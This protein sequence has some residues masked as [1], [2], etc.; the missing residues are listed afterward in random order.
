MDHTEYPNNCELIVFVLWYSK[1]FAWALDKGLKKDFAVCTPYSW[2]MLENT[3]SRV[4]WVH[5]V[6]FIHTSIS[7]YVSTLME[8]VELPASHTHFLPTS[9]LRLAVERC[10]LRLPCSEYKSLG[11]SALY[12]VLSVIHE[13]WPTA[14]EPGAGARCRDRGGLRYHPLSAPC[15]RGWHST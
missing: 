5:C 15:Y 1:Y 14:T 10:G 9:S 7:I 6:K 4:Y 3:N 8:S 13:L 2:F 12:T 11:Q